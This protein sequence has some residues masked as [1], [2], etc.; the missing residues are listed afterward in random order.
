MKYSREE[1]L[2]FVRQED[3][4]FIRLAFCDVFGRLNN[5]AVMVD[6]LERAFDVGAAFDPNRIEG[7]QRPNAYRLLLKPDPSSLTIL[8]WR[9][10]HGRVVRMFCDVVK[11]NGRP[12]EV[13]LRRRLRDAVEL[14]Q[15]KGFRFEFGSRQ[16]F[17]LFRLDEERNE[18]RVPYDN[19]RYMSVYPEDKGENVRREICLTLEQMGVSP[20][21][22]RHEAGP[23]QNEVEFRFSD[24]LTAADRAVTFQSVVKT[25]A[26]RNGLVADF[27]PKPLHEQPGNGFHISIAVEPSENRSLLNQV[28]AGV[29][30]QIADCS[31]FLNPTPESYK[32]LDDEPDLRKIIIPTEIEGT[33]RRLVLRLPDPAANPYLAFNL[34]LR[35]GLAGL[36]Q[37]LDLPSSTSISINEDGDRFLQPSE[38]AVDLQ[39]A[40]RRAQASS[41]IKEHVPDVVVRS[42]CT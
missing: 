28:A 7:F 24:P 3:V 5:L 19:G 32:R 10:E 17:Y 6:E 22:S 41:F 11:P 38:R 26:R 15:S 42:Y 35:A 37:K 29:L 21:C 31:L 18:L 30:R 40:R 1:V 20:V 2:E 14:A 36:D 34:L 23:G 39:D 27:S 9:P 16:V 13:D 12:F 4:K 33:R 25:T 8:P